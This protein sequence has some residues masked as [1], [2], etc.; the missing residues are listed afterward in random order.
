MILCYRLKCIDEPME[1]YRELNVFKIY[2]SDIG[3]L[4]S[5]F[6]D[7]IV[8]SIL[9]NELGI[10][11]GALYENIAAQMLDFNHHKLYYFEPSSHSEIDFILEDEK[12]IYPIEI[13]SAMNTKAR[14]L[15][16]YIEKY[17]PHKAIRFSQ[18]NINCNDVIEDYPLY[19]MMF[20]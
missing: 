1:G 6:K 18:R 16:A 4:I 5:Q 9:S 2:L 3:L 8:Q 14:S 15:K 20:L 11:K 10:Y 19:M 13:K 12:G 17:K 7:S